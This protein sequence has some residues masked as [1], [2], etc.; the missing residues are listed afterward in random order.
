MLCSVRE[1]AH[2]I[3]RATLLARGTQIADGDLS[4]RT[5]NVRMARAAEGSLLRAR[6]NFAKPEMP[7]LDDSTS[8]INLLV[9][10]AATVH[11]LR[12]NPKALAT[13]LN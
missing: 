4:L 3:E 2:K 8:T 9:V 7:A 11:R 1:L 6:A 10:A 13:F 5:S 12:R